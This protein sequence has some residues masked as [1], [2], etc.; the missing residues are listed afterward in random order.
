MDMN[1]EQRKDLAVR[2]ES[3]RLSDYGG[4][5]RRAYNAAG[6]NS[7]TWSKAE[8]GQPIA[9]RSYV[10]IVRTLWPET[11]G[12]WRRMDPPLG[13]GADGW[14]AYVD[15]LN[16]SPETHAHVVATIEADMAKQAEARGRDAG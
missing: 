9:E 15:S 14:R 2:I 3:K 6:V 5:R 8:E 11:Q 1:D 16:L 13:E 7:A 12:D 4:N 10:A